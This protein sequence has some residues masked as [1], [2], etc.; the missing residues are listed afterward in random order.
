MSLKLKS[1]RLESVGRCSWST[2]GSKNIENCYKQ[3]ESLSHSE[4]TDHEMVKPHPEITSEP[5]TVFSEGTFGEAAEHI[6]GKRQGLG[7]D[8][9]PG[10]ERGIAA[11]PP[12]SLAAADLPQH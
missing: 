3:G 9:K 2:C 1:L 11:Q 12:Q 6:S 4:D 10:W 5:T 7:P 8:V